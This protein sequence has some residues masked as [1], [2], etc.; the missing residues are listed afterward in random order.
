MD[1]AIMILLPQLLQTLSHYDTSAVLM[2]SAHTDLPF[3][4]SSKTR[5]TERQV[6]RFPGDGLFERVARAVCRAGCL[7]RKELFEAWEMARRIRRRFRGGRI[8]DLAAGH[9]L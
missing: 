5:L 7:P 3:S 9:G 6:A 1:R 4:M 8:V 2:N